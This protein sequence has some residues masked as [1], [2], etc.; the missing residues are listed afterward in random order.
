M[1]MKSTIADEIIDISDCPC[2]WVCMCALTYDLSSARAFF[3][4][5]LEIIILPHTIPASQ[6]KAYPE[7]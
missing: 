2:Q 7:D 1:S 6:T 4:S 5:D 3:E